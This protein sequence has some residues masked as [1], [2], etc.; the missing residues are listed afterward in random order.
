MTM[1]QNRTNLT[2]RDLTLRRREWLMIYIPLIF[3]VVL[4]LALVAIISALGFREPN[5]GSDPASAWGDTAAI[6]VIVEVAVISLLPL[7]I[8][9]ALCA[10]LVWLIIQIPPYLRQGQEITRAVSARVD[11]VTEKVVTAAI[12]PYLLSARWR[13]TIQLFRR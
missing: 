7:I 9:I 3:G 4:C 1:S 12:K 6:I 8:L 11:E 10:L 5:L 13:V 2:D